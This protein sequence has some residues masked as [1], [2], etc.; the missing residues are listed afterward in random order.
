MKAST[1]LAAI[2]LAPCRTLAAPFCVSVQGLPDQ[3]IYVD[4]SECQSRATQLGGVCIANAAAIVRQFGTSQFCIVTETGTALC[5]YADRN[6]C[7][8]DALR[9]H[10]ACIEAVR[11]GNNTIDPFAIRRPY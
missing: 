3:C 4:G 10:D 11:P 1:L 2:L 6:S 5:A 7:T 9:R 8:A